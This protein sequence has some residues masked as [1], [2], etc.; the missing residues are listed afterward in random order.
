MRYFIFLI[1]YTS[2]AYSEVFSLR[3]IYLDYKYFH[4]GSRNPLIDNS[5]I[6]NRELDQELSLFFNMDLFKYS[7][8]DNQILGLTD[9]R[10][11]SKKKS[12]FRV[13]G[14]NFKVGIKLF[15]FLDAGYHH[16]SKHLLDYEYADWRFPVEDS[17]YLKLYFYKREDSRAL[18]H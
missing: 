8:F 2:T 13:V 11:D 10:A 1:F 14:W 17:F 3:E 5:G 9:R 12:G 18:I 6:E 7:Y 16:F 4:E 15:K